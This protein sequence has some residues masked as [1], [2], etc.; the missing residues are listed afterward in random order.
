MAQTRDTVLLALAC[1]GGAV[2]AP[3]APFFGLPICAAAL[4]GLIYRGLP[5]AAAVVAGASIALVVAIRPTEAL[6]LVPAL[7]GVMLAA[8]AMRRYDVMTVAAWFVPLLAFALAAR[9]LGAAWLSGLTLREYFTD[10]IEE[11]AALLSA[12]GAGDVFAADAVDMM[13][14]LAPAGYLFTALLTAVPTLAAIMWSARK[15]DVE[16]SRSPRIDMLDLSPHV[17]WLLF[18][19]VGAGAA[20]RIW[21]GPD[22]AFATVSLNFLLAAKVVLFVQGFAVISALLKTAKVGRIGLIGA[23]IIALLIDGPTWIV[24]ITGLLDFWINFRKLAR[25]GADGDARMKSTS[26]TGT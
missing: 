4:A 9:E 17:L 5:V 22:G 2:I 21:G 14:R 11:A 1:A 20:A 15:A 12:A 3:I 24:S 8:L 10:V 25:D 16:L 13:L 6:V 23:G 18:V 7:V 26:G 19:G